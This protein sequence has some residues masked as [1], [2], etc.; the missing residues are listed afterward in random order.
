MTDILLNSFIYL[1]AAVIAVPISKKLGLGSVLGYLIAGI[2]IGPILGL[3]GD[4]AKKVQH[5]AEFGVVMMLFLVGLE[6][7]PKKLWSLRH[8]LLGLGGLQVGLTTV[9]ITAGAMAMGLAWQ[10]A[11]AVGL[12]LSLSST[13]IVLQTLN[14]KGLMKS[15]GGQSS[16]SV[17]LFQ[18]IA[19]I[20]MLALMPLL[21]LPELAELLS[22]GQ[23]HIQDAEHG[24]NLLSGLSGGV[25]ALVTFGA[26]GA[27]ILAGN[28]LVNPLFRIIA[29]TGLREI[30]TAFALCL[31]IGIAVLMSSIGLSPALGTFIAGVVL[32]SSEY[33]HELE[34]TIE[35]FKGLLLGVF[36]ITVGAD[37][38]LTLL[39]NN[40]FLIIG[41]TLA[42]IAIKFAVLFMLGKLFKLQG[43][44]HWLFALALAQAGEFGFVLLS[45]TVQNAVIPRAIASQLLL[46]IALSMMLTPLLF[47]LFD[48]FI[49]PRQSKPVREADTI[50]GVSE[51]GIIVAGMGRFG[52]MVTRLLIK[53]GYNPTVIDLDAEAVEGFNKLGYKTYFGDASRPELLVS[54]GIETAKLLVVAI[55][56]KERALAMVAYARKVNPELQIVAR[57]YDRLNTYDLWQ[58]GDG[59]HMNIVR[60]MFDSSV[61]AGKGALEALGFDK[62]IAKEITELFYH[63]N[64][65]GV[66]LMAEA[67]D[68]SLPRFANQK[69]IDIAKK[70]NDE[71]EKMIQNVLA[72]TQKNAASPEIN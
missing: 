66:Q 34:S 36:F 67:H 6:L 69:M 49:V 64:R 58:A 15:T 20:P 71:T 55:D 7:E 50:E 47:I 9:A 62:A 46:V 30:F 23:N 60:E 28:F 70:H 72:K 10:T 35:P 40:F 59:K 42:V 22:H 63:R 38:N 5:V 17:L 19:V 24:G 25:K 12:T 18:D 8:R 3:V 11:L 37:M 54:A 51:Q 52:Q 48:K 29:K 32:A 21:A 1:M 27:I 33:R 68:P 45:V 43:M 2:A 56:D 26:I 61:R 57:G 65:H 53:C 4:E 44:Y 41:A 16:F 31:I 39:A 13:A 14:E